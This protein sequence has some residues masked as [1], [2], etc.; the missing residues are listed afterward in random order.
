MKIEIKI[1]DKRNKTYSKPVSI[2]DFILY[3]NEIEFE[4]ENGDSLPYND[5]IFFGE[6]YCYSIFVNG[7]HIDLEG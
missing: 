7:K 2:E 6:D 5:F 4:W 3:P 1:Y